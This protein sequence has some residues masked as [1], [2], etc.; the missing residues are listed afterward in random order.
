MW[1]ER[2]WENVQ[3]FIVGWNFENNS[4]VVKITE[5][6]WKEIIKMNPRLIIAVTGL[7]IHTVAVIVKKNNK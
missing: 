2:G 7:A 3:K 6:N 5:E 4:K 1:K